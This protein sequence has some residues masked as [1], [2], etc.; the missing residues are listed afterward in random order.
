MDGIEGEN[1]P[2]EL[3]DLSAILRMEA[4]ADIDEAFQYYEDRSEGLGREFL[5]SVEACLAS[6]E[7]NPRA[8]AILYRQVRRSL[9]RRFPYS[10]FYTIEDDHLSVIACLHASRSPRT[11]R[12]RVQ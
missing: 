11:W 1:S 9:L 6:I 4:Q 3:I 7:R 8:N 10:V 2:E 5:R 12:R